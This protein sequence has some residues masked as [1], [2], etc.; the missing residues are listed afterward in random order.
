M[1]PTMLDQDEWYY[2]QWCRTNLKD[3][4]DVGSAVEYED[5]YEHYAAE[6]ARL[7]PEERQQF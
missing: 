7:T 2:R 6:M 5:W 3:P 1:W 4:E